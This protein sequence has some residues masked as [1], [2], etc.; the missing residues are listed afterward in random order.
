MTATNERPPKKGTGGAR[1]VQPD[2]VREPEESER[3]L[4]L[5]VQMR[6]LFWSMGVSTSL[7]VKLRAYVSSDVSAA[8]AGR[9]SPISTCLASGS[10]R[11]ANL[12]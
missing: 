11:P 8:P 7:D 1:P 2:P 3:D 10:R 9:S 6:R 5:K 4:P 12:T